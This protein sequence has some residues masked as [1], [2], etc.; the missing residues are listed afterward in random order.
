[1]V[2]DKVVPRSF[3]TAKS[4]AAG[5]KP[6]VINSLRNNPAYNFIWSLS[7]LNRLSEQVSFVILKVGSKCFN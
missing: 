1:M 3:E 4:V 5:A 6:R 7:W 2:R